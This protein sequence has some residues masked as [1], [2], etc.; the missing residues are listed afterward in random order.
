MMYV[1]QQ[2]CKIS[3]NP[4]LTNHEKRTDMRRHINEN[5]TITS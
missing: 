2:L 4:T 1:I 5:T 3:W